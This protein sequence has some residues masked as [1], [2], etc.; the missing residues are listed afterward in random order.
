MS[1]R[2][3]WKYKR[4]RKF[5]PYKARPIQQEGVWA[6]FEYGE[7]VAT[8]NKFGEYPVPKSWKERLNDH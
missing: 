7:L 1:R 6:I 4:K 2:N 3:R 8:G 5:R